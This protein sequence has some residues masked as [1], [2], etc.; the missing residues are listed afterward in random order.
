MPNI[1]TKVQMIAY[2]INTFPSSEISQVKKKG[3][4]TLPVYSRKSTYKGNDNELIDISKRSAFLVD[5]ITNATAKADINSDTLKVF[6]VPEFFFRGTRGAYSF[7]HYDKLV[8]M[9]KGMIEDDKYKH[10]L[11]VF[12]SV[13]LT[14]KGD[15]TSTSLEG[16]ENLIQNVVLVSKGGAGSE[17]KAVVKEYMSG[18]DFI[19]SGKEK[20]TDKLGNE[21]YMIDGSLDVSALVKSQVVHPLAAKSSGQGREAQSNPD[22]GQSIV[23]I[24]GITIGIEIC[25]DHLMKR[26]RKSPPALM[27]KYIQ[28][29]LIPSAGMEIKDES[30]VAVK[31]GVV[32]NC[33]GNQRSAVKIVKTQCA[34]DKTAAIFQGV[35]PVAVLSD[36]H[37]ATVLNEVKDYYVADG[38]P[39]I[40]VYPVELIP[41]AV[42][43]TTS[44]PQYK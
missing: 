30:T 35:V 28:L 42:Q 26:L 20:R 1:Y 9:L 43:R 24:D 31:G 22:S 3:W 14:W 2:E 4:F 27:Q 23:D 19:K 32:F 40:A 11:F 12:G 38:K 13:L 44:V 5:A 15:S 39:Q 18:I 36:A 34:G 10:W 29:Q 16:T 6:M 33:D 41:A 17:M 25:L 8:D 21:Y 37:N 7:D